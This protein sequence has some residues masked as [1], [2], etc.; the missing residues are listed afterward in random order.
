[1]RIQL[2]TLMLIWIGSDFSDFDVVPDPVPHQSDANLEHRLSNH[3]RVHCEPPRLH[4]EPL[5][6]HVEP[7][8]HQ[9][10]PPCY[11]ILTLMRIR[12]QLLTLIRILIQLFTSGAADSDH[13]MKH[14]HEDPDPE[15]MQ[16]HGDPDPEIKQIHG[17][18]D[19]QRCREHFDPRRKPATNDVHQ[20]TRSFVTIGY[21]VFCTVVRYCT[22]VLCILCIL[23]RELPCLTGLHTTASCIM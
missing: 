20:R 12:N 17:D 8:W 19:P 5:W 6:L 15:T 13:E 22:V 23:Y 3:P 7:P 9:F 14:I 2:F 11:S 21:S 18:P 10:E 1:M 4:F 16:I